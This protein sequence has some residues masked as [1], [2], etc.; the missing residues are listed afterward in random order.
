MKKISL[1]ADFGSSGGTRTYF[2][3]LINYFSLHH[4]ENC[5]ETVYVFLTKEQYD[6]EIKEILSASDVFFPIIL[7]K[8]FQFTIISK[9]FRKIKLL[10]WYEFILEKLTIKKI[11]K[12]NPDAMIFSIGNS[13][14]YLYALTKKIPALFI[15]HTLIQNSPVNK[16]YRKKVYVKIKDQC[17]PASRLCSVSEKG[18]KLYE[19]YMPLKTSLYTTLLN[20]GGSSADLII[21]KE[22]NGI[23]ILTLGLLASFKNPDLWL[24]VAKEITDSFVQQDKQPPQF[25]WAGE[26]TYYERLKNEAKNYVN[27]TFLGFVKDTQ[28]LYSIADIYVQPS[29]T[30]NCCLSVIEAMKYGLPCVVSNVGGL[31]EQIENKKNGYLC[32]YDEQKQF[33]VAIIRLIEDKKLRDIYGK[34]GRNIFEKKYTQEQW[35]TALQNL[36]RTIL[37]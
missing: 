34:N 7:P 23:I 18:K 35:N 13:T 3:Q 5:I 6:S 33:K 12:L 26:G 17:H 24:N 8:I 31:P 25:I 29:T 19:Q 16:P 9:I 15:S 22:H 37:S 11:L 27:I 2:K 4:N 21:K 14:K 28:R 10:D 32:K 30:E 1:I 20:H 36:L